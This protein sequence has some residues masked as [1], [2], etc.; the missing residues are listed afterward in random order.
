MAHLGGD[1]MS[2]SFWGRHGSLI[3]GGVVLAVIF[4]VLLPGWRLALDLLLTMNLFAAALALLLVL[5]VRRPLELSSFPA[6]M[7]LGSLF[8][9]ALCIAAA[10]LIIAGTE[11]GTLV[12]LVGRLTSVGGPVSAIMVALVLAVVHL[13]VISAGA[14]RAAEV[15]ARFSLDALPGKQLGVDSAVAAG[16]LADA[17]AQERRVQLQAEADF[18][19]AMDGATRFARGEAIACVAIVA[20]SLV[21]GLITRLTA[22][23]ASG[24]GQAWA[25]LA[26]LCAG[27]AV[28]ILVPALLS[29]VS[30]ALLVTRGAGESAAAEDVVS[31]MRLHPG[32]LWVTA[33]VLL[34][35]AAASPFFGGGILGAF[36][37]L[38]VA[39][40]A[41]AWVLWASR[42]GQ[43][44]APRA[45]R[46][47][48]PASLP[49]P[50]RQPSPPAGGIEIRLGLGLIGIV[51]IEGP[52][53]LLH[54]ASS[55]RTQIAND[56]Y[57]PM[58]PIVVR[59]SDALR[60][61]EYAFWMRGQ[62]M[63]RGRLMISKLLAVARTPRHSPGRGDLSP[64]WIEPGQAPQWR[65]NG[66]VV[67]TSLEALLAHFEAVL[68][69][70]AP[71]LI[72]RQFA[73][74][75]VRGVEVSRPAVAAEL[76]RRQVS[77]GTVRAALEALVDEGLALSD[78]VAIL[79]GILD[80]A[81]EGGLEGH[82]TAKAQH[83]AEAAR[84]YLAPAITASCRSPDGHIYALT[85]GPN[86]EQFVA[87]AQ[88]DAA[89]GV[90]V[91]LPPTQVQSLS[92]QVQHIQA[93]LSNPGAVLCLVCSPV[94]RRSVRAALAEACPD[95]RV[96]SS[97]ELLP[98]AQIQHLGSVDVDRASVSL[99]PEDAAARQV[100]RQ[101]RG[102]GG[103][104]PS[105]S[106]R[107]SSGTRSISEG[108]L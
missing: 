29:C 76:D 45:R 106:V 4:M 44:G 21:G 54:Q 3:L 93:Y 34:L 59:D 47:A 73:Q 71:A 41:V 58:P 95:L 1:G 60:A 101:L 105:E 91:P 40:V 19:G 10:R 46:D 74:A 31:Q 6:L 18:Y 87:D 13:V 97:E 42:Q 27:L 26:E 5:S 79:E 32:T 39:A 9:L 102:E 104:L 96:I 61:S 62:E 24:L 37:P 14:G 7:L 28:V 33:V 80:S 30:A 92:G 64:M 53:G 50:G 108:G 99:P 67:L 15:A 70:H 98:D 8:R 107:P 11:P 89:R 83:A 72:D 22:A 90:A 66:F 57:V 48:Q 55:I 77:L 2:E 94:A 23:R 43:H 56:T 36:P 81:E 103:R 100:S 35:L 16:A 17:E 12:P 51:P 20:L 75:L 88:P 82:G 52:Q 49:Q 69:R 63:G 78:P 25:L 85:L 68:R 84:R 86:A 38:L 65:A